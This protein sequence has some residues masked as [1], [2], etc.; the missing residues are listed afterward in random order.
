LRT[1]RHR[2]PDSEGTYERPGAAIGQTRL[3]IIDLVTGDPPITN[4]AG[5]VGVAL[6]GE[7]Y[8]YRELR[9]ELCRRGS[10]LHT[11]G[12]TEVIAHLAERL[13][14]VALARRLHGMF[15][16]AVWDDERRRLVLGRDRLGKKPL[17]YWAGDQ[18]FVFGSEIKAVLA[19]PAVPRR[20]DPDALSAYLTFGYVPTPRTFF[21][22]VVSLPPGHVLTVEPGGTPRIETYWQPR[23]P[24]SGGVERLDLGFDE[25]A[26]EVRR[27]VTVAVDRRLIA[28]VPLGAF[29]SGGIDSSSVVGLMAQLSDKPVSTFTIGFEDQQGF[30]ERPYARMVAER[31]QTDHV[32][33]VVKPDAAELIDRLVWHHDQPFG[34]SSALPTFLLSELTR[35]HVTV[36]LC[37]DGGDELFAGYERFAAALIR[38]RLRRVPGP[39][40]AGARRAA[41][42][43]S[44]TRLKSRTGGLRRLLAEPGQDVPRAYL[45]WISYTSAEWRS[46]LLPGASDWGFDDYTR[47]WEA[48]AGGGVLDRL[49]DLNLR[50]YLLDDLL[51]KV[52]RTSMAHGLEVRAPFLDT[53]LVEFAL[54]LPE[55]ARIRGLSLKRVL[56]AAMADVLPPEVVNRPKR[57][58]GIPLDRWLRTDLRSYTEGMLTA[59]SARVRA[60]LQ[61]EA[62]DALLAE[63][64]SGAASNGHAI[65]TLLTLEA[66][67]RREGW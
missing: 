46:A 44:A 14:P 6:N 35:E 25:A 22:G 64:Q 61:P 39:V 20:M 11:Q 38:H 31:W 29:L 42:A 19:H 62:I 56:K 47:I 32:E 52:D 1:L 59:P 50:T 48:S 34:D 66:F 51:P 63:H 8:N 28:D 27:L 16:F 24:G 41:D 60:H 49:L 55:P 10:S 5:T 26:A 4:D 58:F 45:S 40:L 65:W 36:A 17:Y 7:I 30:D 15:A 54:R 3:A 67:L 43:L 18:H 33:F 12:D 37:G 13:E 21:E 53:D 23:V 2:G 9:D 57:G